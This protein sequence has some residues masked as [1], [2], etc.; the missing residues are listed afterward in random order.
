MEKQPRAANG[1]LLALYGSIVLLALNGIFAKVIPLDAVTISQ[2]RSVVACLVL[3]ALVLLQQRRFRLKSWRQ[4]LGVY[5]LGLLLGWH[6][7]TYFH[8]MQI[9]SVAIGMLALFSYPVITVVL[10]PMFKQHLPRLA[11][12][13]AA[14]VVFLGVLLMV[15]RDIFSGDFSGAAFQGAL[16]GVGSAFLF[17]LRNTTQK[18]LFPQVDSLTLMAHQSL[19]VA[20][21]LL[22]FLSAPG[23]RAMSLIDWFWLIILGCFSTAM[24]HTLLSVALKQLAAKSVALISCAIPVV[25]SLLAWSILGEAPQLMVYI[26]GAVILSVAAYETLKQP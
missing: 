7:M 19:A 21:M 22:P 3:V 10:E 11:D 23:L 5:G 15:S 4:A 14:L 2:T 6:W 12:V 26:G 16:F 1:G 24:A 20:L 18:Y 9:S 17:S 13:V 25:G 8:A